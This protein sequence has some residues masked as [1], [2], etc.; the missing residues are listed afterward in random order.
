MRY[1]SEQVRI[2][3]ALRLCEVSCDEPGQCEEHA[4]ARAAREKAV[5]K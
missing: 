3:V 2:N 4:W 5:A 1:A